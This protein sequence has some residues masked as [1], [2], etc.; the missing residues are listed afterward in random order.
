MWAR[1]IEAKVYKEVMGRVAW[2][3][4]GLGIFSVLAVCLV[5]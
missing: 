4:K 1:S 3:E 2:R 5:S